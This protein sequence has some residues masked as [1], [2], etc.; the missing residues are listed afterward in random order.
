MGDIN[1]APEFPLEA[2][3]LLP[4]G[5][6]IKNAMGQGHQMTAYRY[7]KDKLKLNDI[8]ADPDLVLQRKCSALV[9]RYYL[10]GRYIYLPPVAPDY[11][12]CLYFKKAISF[13]RENGFQIQNLYKISLDY[14]DHLAVMLFHD[15]EAENLIYFPERKIAYTPT[16]I[17]NRVKGCYEYNCERIGD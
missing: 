8:I 13:Y 17:Y 7:L 14:N 3:F 9:I 11:S 10:G 6:H 5:E 1:I 12:G 15:I 16:V 4:N 2:G